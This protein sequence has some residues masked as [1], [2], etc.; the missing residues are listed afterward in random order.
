M[1]V[2]YSLL[3][4][5]APG[6]ALCY[7]NVGITEIARHQGRKSKTVHVW[8]SVYAV[9]NRINGV[10]PPTK[11]IKASEIPITSFLPNEEDNLQ[12]RNR[13]EIIIQRI[14]VAHL[15]YF[16]DSVFP[17]NIHHKYSENQEKKSDVVTVGILQVN[18]GTTD[19]NI[20]VLEHLHQHVPFPAGR[21]NP[22]CGVPVHGDAA[23]VLGMMKAKISREH[24]KTPSERLEGVWPVPGEFHRRM[25]AMQDTWSELY[26]EGSAGEPG[27]LMDIRNKFQMKSVTKKV[28]DCFN[29]AE[30]LLHLSTKGLICLAA[31]DLLKI[32]T[33]ETTTSLG[34]DELQDCLVDTARKIATFFWHQT[35]L[36][37]VMNVVEA[38][39]TEVVDEF[40]FCKKHIGKCL[41]EEFKLCRHIKNRLGRLTS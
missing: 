3:F 9:L 4:A 1:F 25:L 21:G 6:Y 36:T 29:H 17:P 18:P 28:S 26:K 20:T 24:N 7:D 41:D 27:T 33:P 34:D 38:E 40:C 30:D 13:M 22:P 8:T 19:G 15:K 35:P 16:E 32:T 31:M 37:D 23:T 10:D 39:V 14:L 12:R 2:I 5:D 11:S